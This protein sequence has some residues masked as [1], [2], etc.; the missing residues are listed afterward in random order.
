M[1]KAYGI[2]DISSYLARRL[3]SMV[4]VILILLLLV[5]F[6]VVYS[7][8]VAV[9]Q[10]LAPDVPGAQGILDALQYAKWPVMIIFIFLML[11]LVYRVT[12]DVKLRFRQVWP[13]ALLATAGLL[14]LTQ[15][16]TLYLS[17]VARTFSSYGAVG[18]F[19]LLMIWVNFSVSIVL[20]GTVLNATISECYHGPA[21]EV[22]S[23]V[24]NALDKL[25]AKVRD[26]WESKRKAPPAK[27]DDIVPEDGAPPEDNATQ[28]TEAPQET[29][30]GDNRE[31]GPEDGHT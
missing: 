5:A 14:V 28:D 27:S 21:Q 22:R 26:W 23:R 13:G 31:N 11:L 2:P 29:A 18:A 4:T 8:G 19:F 12:P 1:N 17:Y 10:A 7:F 15:L 9:L 6:A 16:F 30:T 24:D 25:L 3:L 20:V